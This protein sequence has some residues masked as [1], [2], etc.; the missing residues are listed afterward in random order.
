MPYY[1]QSMPTEVGIGSLQ[2]SHA[3]SGWTA[4]ALRRRSHGEKKRHTTIPEYF[5]YTG[6]GSGPNSQKRC[7]T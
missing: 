1:T 2:K 4:A 6:C 3:Y 5:A 7:K